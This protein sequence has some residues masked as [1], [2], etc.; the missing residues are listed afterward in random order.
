[1]GPP[2]RSPAADAHGCIMVR[3]RAGSTGYKLVARGSA[4]KGGLPSER[5]ASNR[6][7]AVAAA[8]NRHGRKYGADLQS[9]TPEAPYKQNTASTRARPGKTKVHH[10]PEKMKVAPS[11]TMMP[12]SA[13]GGRTPR[14]MNERPAAFR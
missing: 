12:H 11:L 4:P 13:A 2:P 1:M 10:S 3:T 8:S 6:G 9:L 14:P 5:R 7:Q